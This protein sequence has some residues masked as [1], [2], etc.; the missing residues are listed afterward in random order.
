[1]QIH[2]T[3]LLSTA[4]VLGAAACGGAADSS[5]ASEFE[6]F[7]IDWGWGLCIPEDDC[8]GFVELSSDGALRLNTPC[9]EGI[10]CSG[11]SEGDYQAVI[12][13]ADL[14]A[15]RAKLTSA[16]LIDILASQDAPCSP[17]ADLSE[18]MALTLEVEAYENITTLCDSPPIAAS[19]A[20][21]DDLVAR[22]F[23][24][25]PI[26]LTAGGW[27][28]GECIDDCVG[29]LALTGDSLEYTIHSWDDSEPPSFVATATLTA[30]GRGELQA[31]LTGLEDATL[32]EVYGCPDCADGG[33]SWV[34]LARDGT[35]SDHTYEYS[36]PPADL[37]AIDGLVSAWMSALASCAST[38]AVKIDAGCVPRDE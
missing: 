2:S 23:V 34:R 36:R 38:E 16:A 5:S 19:R 4:L 13:A 35:L 12:S 31:A 25:P 26:A 17:V 21:F 1:M 14:D 10:D 8:T 11:L 15:A 32:D 27:S 6:Q 3:I 7:R 37:E 29:D 9:I 22:Y 30:A 33:L 20:V 18:R 28:F 24:A